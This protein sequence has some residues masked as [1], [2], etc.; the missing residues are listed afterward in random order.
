[1]TDVPRTDRCENCEREI[2]TELT[3]LTGQHELIH[4]A[5]RRGD[6]FSMAKAGTATVTFACSC[7]Y[8]EVEYAPGKMRVW[9]LPDG[10]KW[11]G[12]IDD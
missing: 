6:G 5:R 4:Q 8:V 2:T 12:E 1:M 7:S 9:E 11:E 3:Q 10:W